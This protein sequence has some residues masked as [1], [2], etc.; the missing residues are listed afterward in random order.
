MWIYPL[1]GGGYIL[2]TAHG[3]M[4][5]MVGGRYTPLWDVEMPANKSSRKM[6]GASRKGVKNRIE[7]IERQRVT[8]F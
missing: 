1:V 3:S 5:D 4:G 2:Y 6:R 7:G 8:I